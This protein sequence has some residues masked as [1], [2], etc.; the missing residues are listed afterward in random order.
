LVTSSKTSLKNLFADL[1]DGD[2]IFDGKASSV[3]SIVLGGKGDDSIS[4]GSGNDILAGGPG[5]DVLTG[6]PGRD[7]FVDTKGDVIVDFQRGI[8][9][10]KDTMMSTIDQSPWLEEFIHGEKNPNDAINI[11]I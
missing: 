4:T 5:R 2:D 6:G 11:T 10:L 3:N 8:D 1:G 7:T 9:K